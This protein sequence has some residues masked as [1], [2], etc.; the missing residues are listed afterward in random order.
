[1][2]TMHNDLTV[3]GGGIAGMCA[4]LAAARHGLKVALVNDRPVLGGNASSEVAVSIS[5]AASGGGSRSV[6]AREGGLVE[7]IKLTRLGYNQMEQ[8]SQSY[9]DWP[10]ED[11]AFLDLIISEPNIRLY[12]NTSVRDV[13]MKNGRIL[14]LKAVQVGSEKDIRFES[15]LFIDATGDATVGFK[16]GAGY[17]WGEEAASEYGEPLAPEK[18]T[19]YVM[20]STLLLFSRDAG[21]PVA[22]RK[23]DFAYDITKLKYFKNFQNDSPARGIHREGNAFSGFWW[24]E[25]GGLLDTI[26]D[27]ESITMELR[28]LVYGV[29]D[30]IKNSGKFKNTENLLLEK[31]S[32]IA[33]KRESRRLIGGHILTENEI[34]D[35][36]DFPDAAA[37]GGWSMDVHAREGIYDKGP[38]TYWHPNN[39]AYNIPFRCLYSKNIPNLMMAGRDI[40]CTHIALGSTRVM[41]TCGCEGQ[42]AGTAA[43]LCR[44][45]HADPAEIAKQYP[46]QLQEVLLRDD[47]TIIGVREPYGEGLTE[48]I[49]VTASS[50]QKYENASVCGYLNP[51]KYC[52]ALPVEEQLDSM[53]IRIANPGNSAK[54]LKLAIFTGERPENYIPTRHVKD[55]SALIPAGFCGWWKVDPRMKAGRDRK[56]YLMF[57]ET[58]L[59]FGFGKKL[60][61]P[62]S[63]RWKENSEL[64]RYPKTGPIMLNRIEQEL[65]FRNIAP[66][67]HMYAAKNLINGY[68]RPYGLPNLWA[69]AGAGEQQIILSWDN[70]KKIQEI[71]LVFDTELEYE[72]FNAPIPSLIRD[73]T[74]EIVSGD[75]QKSQQ[76]VTDNYLRVRRHHPSFQSVRGIRL[77]LQ[78]TWGVQNKRMYAVRLY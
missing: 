23:P 11:A 72:N 7:E 60:V 22:Y 17:M 59:L 15:P 26:A 42:A 12:L 50:E 46:K 69:S 38:A 51:G 36:A 19:R 53:E 39:G 32:H 56:I 1:M 13:E 6:Y 43:W 40:S 63:F 64:K 8:H 45:Y 55:L 58:G 62:V 3:A 14:A 21:H 29:W 4:A 44:K 30:Y 35:K 75:G 20:G 41:G 78:S 25:I 27:N 2:E 65:C 48:G 16:A 34:E 70:P 49:T 24:I 67:Q 37:I 9:Q 47:Q 28:K 52:L 10:M 57:N 61:G 54:E 31:V 71:Q 77:T 73:Y 33:G 18:A 66:E 5:G 74:L 76:N 68:S